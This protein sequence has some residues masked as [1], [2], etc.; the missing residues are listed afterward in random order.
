MHRTI[1]L[2]LL[3]NDNFKTKET[4]GLDRKF[5]GPNHPKEVSRKKFPCQC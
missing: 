5:H 2:T 3:F 1:S 4:Q